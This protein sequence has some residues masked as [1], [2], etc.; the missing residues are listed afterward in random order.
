MDALSEMMELKFLAIDFQDVLVVEH[1]L[2]LRKTL[3]FTNA[4][5]QLLYLLRN[6]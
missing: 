3:G 4:Q 2:A 1:L 5:T 6:I